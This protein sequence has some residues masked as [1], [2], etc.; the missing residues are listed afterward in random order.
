M[1]IFAL[2]ALAKRRWKEGEVRKWPKCWYAPVDS[3]EE[4]SLALRFT[5]SLPTTAAVSPG[6][7]ELLWWA[8][9]A[10]EQYNPLSKE[11]AEMLAEKSRGLDPIFKN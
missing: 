1:A 5:L 3:P 7:A 2:K 6:H 11:E 8:C 9:E 4:A 10:A